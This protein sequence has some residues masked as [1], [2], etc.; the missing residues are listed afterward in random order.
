MAPATTSTHVW[1]VRW[2][3]CVTAA[4]PP[5]ASPGH[6]RSRLRAATSTP[7]LFTIAQ[8]PRPIRAV[9]PI[10]E[11][12]RPTAAGLATPSAASEYGAEMRTIPTILAAA[13][14]A[15]GTTV[16]SVPV[17]HAKPCA[18]IG[19]TS[20]A[21]SDCLL[22]NPNQWNC[23]PRP[24]TPGA[25]DAVS[26]TPCLLPSQGGTDQ[27]CVMPNPPAVDEQTGQLC[28]NGPSATCVRP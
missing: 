21:C 15:V 18:Y 22:A 11:I 23:D 16:L 7:T 1:H 4:G 8:H 26:Q 25:V 12:K 13:A 3:Q 17:A 2:P 27:S 10:T 9:P 24:I 19:D 6:Q 14:I 20:Q 5:Y 28:G